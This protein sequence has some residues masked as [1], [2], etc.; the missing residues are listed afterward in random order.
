MVSRDFR[1]HADQL[2]SPRF[3]VEE[4]TDGGPRLV[5][6]DRR[7]EPHQC[8]GAAH[9]QDIADGA[10]FGPVGKYLLGHAKPILPRRA[11]GDASSRKHRR[12]TVAKTFSLH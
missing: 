10:P 2:A 1:D 3:D 4:R 9:A 11:Q 6:V 5:G 8:L 7:R 12:H